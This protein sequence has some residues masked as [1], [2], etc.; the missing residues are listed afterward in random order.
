[1]SES[2]GTLEAHGATFD[3]DGAK[4]PPGL[5]SREIIAADKE[6]VTFREI[7][8]PR[9]KGCPMVIFD[10]T[11]DFP[12]PMRTDVESVTHTFKMPR[13]ALSEQSSE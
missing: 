5:V 3:V 11:V 12:W 9:V 1:M 6:T 7:W 4:R 13:A 2:H 8:D 10:R